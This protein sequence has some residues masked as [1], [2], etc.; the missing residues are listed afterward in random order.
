MCKKSIVII[1]V[2]TL[3]IS[4][5]IQNPAYSEDTTPAE[6]YDNLI[7]YY[8]CW[9]ELAS[10]PNNA[11]N[12]VKAAEY[13][14][15]VV[16]WPGQIFSYN[17]VVGRRTKDRGFIFGQYMIPGGRHGWIVGGG[18]CMTASILHQAVKTVPGLTPKERHNHV[19]PTNYL[20]QGEDAAIWWDKQDYK[21]SNDT[22]TPIKIIAGAEN[23]YLYIKIEN[24]I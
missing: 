21:F 9:L 4:I 14:N 23:D 22:D 15:G 3:V 5:I 13:L 1:T 7:G 11:L 12:A 10:S 2:L 6:N 20:P 16:I 24:A 17:Q 19:N 18:I 8:Q